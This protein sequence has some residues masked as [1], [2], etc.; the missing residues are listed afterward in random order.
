MMPLSLAVHNR[1]PGPVGEA[2]RAIFEGTSAT[3]VLRDYSE[4]CQ[5]LQRCA[6][7]PVSVFPDPSTGLA[8][9]TLGIRLSLRKLLKSLQN[10]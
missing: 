2:S 1:A 10:R 7:G 9:G 3:R 4:R 6:P 5:H 8:K